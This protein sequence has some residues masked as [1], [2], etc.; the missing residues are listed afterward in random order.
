MVNIK[1]FEI[2][3]SIEDFLR[4]NANNYDK[5]FVIENNRLLKS[6][7]LEEQVCWNH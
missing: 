2:C 1:L 7:Y 4:E 5:I 6:I 3:T